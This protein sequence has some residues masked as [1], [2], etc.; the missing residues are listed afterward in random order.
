MSWDLEIHSRSGDLIWTGSRDLLE[1]SG[2]RLDQQRIGV[3]LRIMEGSFHYDEEGALG[4]RLHQS[5]RW[6]LE[7]AQAEIPRMVTE[8][9]EPMDD[10]KVANVEIAVSEEDPRQIGIVISYVKLLSTTDPEEGEDD[11]EEIT[12]VVPVGTGT[13]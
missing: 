8:A 5:L 7:R 10:I 6:S 3:R 11:R 12:V 9:L 4:S 13:F 1:I 2:E